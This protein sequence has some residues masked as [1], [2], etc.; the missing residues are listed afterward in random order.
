MQVARRLSVLRTRITQRSLSA[1]CSGG[2]WCVLS[3][4][5]EAPTTGKWSGPGRGYGNCTILKYTVGFVNEYLGGNTDPCDR[6]ILSWASHQ[7]IGLF[8]VTV[9][10]AYR[11]MV[12]SAADDSARLGHNTQS[13]SLYWSGKAFFMWHAGKETALTGPKAR[14]IGVYVD[15]QEG[16]LAFYRVSHNQAQEICCVHTHFE[17]PLFPSFRFWSGVGSTITICELE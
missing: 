17:G 15:Q 5:L 7:S 9:G 8:Q 2:R 12:R 6:W 16:L 14:R 13:W 10:V 4:W 11:D 1:S 3:R